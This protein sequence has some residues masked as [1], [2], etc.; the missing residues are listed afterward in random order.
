MDSLRVA[1]RRNPEGLF[2]SGN[3]PQVEKEMRMNGILRWI[4][5]VCCLC[6][7]PGCGQTDSVAGIA[8]EQIA[9]GNELAGL[10]EGGKDGASL[11]ADKPKMKP[12]WD[13]LQRAEARMK[14][15]PPV[16]ENGPEFEKCKAD[17]TKMVWRLF[18]AVMAI[19]KNHPDGLAV[20]KEVGIVQESNF[21]GFVGGKVYDVTPPPTAPGKQ[22]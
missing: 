14:A 15:L 2:L 20:L 4:A 5:L 1:L 16:P 8:R 22:R 12:L 11:E 17:V 7:M 9:A 13:R 19:R 10:L 18:S 21:G 6:F 3:A